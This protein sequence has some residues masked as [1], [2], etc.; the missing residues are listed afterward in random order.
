MTCRHVLD[1]IDAGPF[2]DYP[3]ARLDAAWEHAHHCVTCGRALEA[4]AALTTDLAAL[5]RPA[6]PP[7]LAAIVMARIARIEQ[8]DPVHGTAMMADRKARSRTRD[9][10][11]WVALVGLAAGMA[12]VLLTPL[13]DAPSLDFA[14]PMVRGIT[15]ALVVVPLTTTGMLAL[16]S[17]L[18][19]YG[20]ALWA[21]LADRRR[22]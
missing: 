21:P 19:L 4:A 3:R 18:V 20:A 11:A 8:A 13:G 14:L 2:A 22:L 5:P 9:R 6:P 1:L 15:G 12:I 17:G 16:A 7:D 10:S